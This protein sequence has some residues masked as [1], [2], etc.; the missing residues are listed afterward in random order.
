MCG[1]FVLTTPADAIAAEFGAEA[2]GLVLT[3]RYNIA[4]MQE[5]VV[6]RSTDGVRRLSVLRWGLIPA[7][8]KDPSIASR[9][10]NARSETAASKPSFRDAMKKRRCIVP[11][12]G[13]YEWR[14]EGTRK[15]PWYFRSRDPRRSLAIAAVW[16]RW[17]DPEGQLVETCCLL[18]TGANAICA[19]VHDRMPVLLDPAGVER[20]LDASLTSADDLAE[21][22]TPAPEDRL[23][24]HAVSTA[25]NS[26]RNDD[27]RN[28]DE[29]AGE[30][31]APQGEL[32]F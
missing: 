30:V 10:I 18:T 21:L 14:K 24:A 32:P 13:F 9:M 5:V 19:P 20:W 23:G 31:A 2:G 4:P 28:V 6:V 26:V 25:V 11:A 17:R 22:L 12:S 1:R 8:A 29:I 7:W 16:E 27:A 15:Q 3:P